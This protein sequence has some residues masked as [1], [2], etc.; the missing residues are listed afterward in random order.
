MRERLGAIA[1]W[2]DRAIAAIGRTVMWAALAVVLVQF[3]I[4]VLRYAFGVGSIRFSESVIYFH[5]ALF[6]LAAAWVLQE[7]AHVRVDVFYAN[8]SPRAKALIDLLGALL[9]LLPFVGVIAWFAIPYAAR[10][11]A[12]LERSRETSGLPFVYL[13]KTLIPLFAVLLGLQGVSQAVRAA[14]ILAQPV[15]PRDALSE[16]R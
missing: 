8:A 3:T 5:A 9:L 15:V 10:S 13:L 12:L 16:G 7:N 4:V 14:L 6:M 11:W 2:I 1:D